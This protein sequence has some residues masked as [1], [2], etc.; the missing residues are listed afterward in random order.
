MIP[1]AH[2]L[3]AFPFVVR[4]ITPA[5]RSIRSNLHEAA[6]VMGADPSRVWREVDLPILDGRC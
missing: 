1:L 6:Q 4:T 2:S 3:V 5:L